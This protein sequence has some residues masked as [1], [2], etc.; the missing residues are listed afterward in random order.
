MSNP[1]WY[2]ELLLGAIDFTRKVTGTQDP[3]IPP[4][5]EMYDGPRGAA[6]FKQNGEEFFKYF[7]EL[8]G[9]KPDDTVLDM[10]SGMGRKTLPLT[11]YL[12]SNGRYEGID[13]VK[14]GVEWC[15]S[16]IGSRFPNFHFQHIDVFNRHYNPF[17]K[18]QATE[19]RFPFP[20]RKFD[21]VVLGSVFTHMLPDAVDHYMS[22]ISRVLKPGGRSMITYLL[23]NSQSESLIDVGK[24][25]FKLPHKSEHYRVEKLSDPEDTTALSESFVRQVYD[26]HDCA[27]IE[28]IQY[29][30]W[31][32]RA[33]YLSFQD[34]IIAKKR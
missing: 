30:S 23:L 20:D 24:G 13:I 1:V 27:I 11:S 10:G 22:E 32:G 8:G 7:T 26:K 3:L 31:C 16:H 4:L 28:P 25:E 18:F 17:G 34:I 2:K 19:F 14:S 21:F 33:K 5:R 12:S 29:G 6:I 15:S 9:L